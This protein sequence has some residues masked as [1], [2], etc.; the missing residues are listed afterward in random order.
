M[1][2]VSWSIV[3]VAKKLITETKQYVCIELCILLNIE[4]ME[5]PPYCL[6]PAPCDFW[7]EESLKITTI[8]L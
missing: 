7:F 2:R 4:V 1:A 8:S 5:H 3:Q 6:D